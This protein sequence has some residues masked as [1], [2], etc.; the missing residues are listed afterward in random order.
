[1][2]KIAI[3][4][5]LLVL[6]V[7]V[8][9]AAIATAGLGSGAPVQ[10]LQYEAWLKSQPVIESSAWGIFCALGHV[11]DIIGIALLFFKRRIGVFFMIGGFIA[12]IGTSSGL[13]YLET[14]LSSIL[15]AL[16]NI[17]WGAIM[18]FVFSSSKDLFTKTTNV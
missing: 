4:R 1:M 3:L 18:A 9:A 2:K 13:P 16:V 12:C 14:A 11:A 5:L 17:L 15:M 10:A 7:L 8:Y 6:F